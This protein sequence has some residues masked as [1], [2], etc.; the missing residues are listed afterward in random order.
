MHILQWTQLDR[1]PRKIRANTRIQP[2]YESI[3]WPGGNEKSPTCW[4]TD[5]F[6]P[7]FCDFW[8]QVVPWLWFRDSHSCLCM[9]LGI[10]EIDFR[11][12]SL[13]IKNGSL[14]LCFLWK[15]WPNYRFFMVISLIFAGHLID[16]VR[17]NHRDVR[18]ISVFSS[19]KSSEKDPSSRFFRAFDFMLFPDCENALYVF[20]EYA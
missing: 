20:F 7:C 2:P 6:A 18:H 3:E 16:F 11:L 8:M 5:I 13:I 15:P 12:W 4:K 9:C 1:I 14:A 17:W 10:R 19:E